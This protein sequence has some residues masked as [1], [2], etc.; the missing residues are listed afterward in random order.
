VHRA[1]LL[2]VGEAEID[3]DDQDA[4]DGLVSALVNDATAVVNALADNEITAAQSEAV[5]LLALVV[6]QDVEPPPTG[7]TVPV[8]GGRSHVGWLRTG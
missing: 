3:W 5:A 1:R 7:R 2:H 6:G 4:K 8:D